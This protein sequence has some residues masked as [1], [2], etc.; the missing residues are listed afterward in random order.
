[1][2]EDLHGRVMMKH[3]R[4]SLVDDGGDLITL[5]PRGHC[6]TTWTV[7]FLIQEIL[8]NKEIAIGIMSGTEKLAKEIASLMA[9]SM[10][11][12]K[13]LQECFPDVVPTDANPPKQW[14]IRGYRLPTR[15]SNRVDPTLVVGSVSSNVTGTHPDILLLD[16]I[17]FGRKQAELAAAEEAYLKVTAIMPPQGRI[18]ING[19]R[20][21]D[22]DLYGKILSGDYS[23]NLGPYKPLVLSCW[24]NAQKTEPIYP[25]EVRSGMTKVSGF[26]Y[27]DL[28]RRK[29]N[30]LFF[31]NCQYLNDPAPEEDQQ[32]KVSDLQYFKPED[33][34]VFDRAH[35]IGVEI[36]GPSVTFPTI[37]YQVTRELNLSIFLQEIS[38]PRRKKAEGAVYAT[39]GKEDRI[40]GAVAPLMMNQNLYLAEW[41]ATDRGGLVDEIRRFGASR[42]DDV[43][44]AL[45]MA[46][47]Y[48]AS[49]IRPEP[50]QNARLHIAADLA[51]SENN[52]ADWS[53]FIAYAVDFKGRGFVIDYKRFRQKSPVIIAQELIK[54]YQSINAQASRV[55]YNNNRTTKFARSYA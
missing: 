31:F 36:V 9:E 7:P 8:N 4:Q 32:M 43:I 55:P 44:D 22:G 27:D 49:G 28:Q 19:T 42:H 23:G 53:V 18:L 21:D 54:F 48:M 46:I 2:D 15:E 39:T 6:K 12:N 51:F 14:G 30:N 38:P 24:N 34:P 50:G 35:A 41:M 20:W 16:D 1:M 45:H 5:I 47:A 17:V 52:D 37:F 25:K 3:Y 13:V 33:A 10:S 26:S 11:G 29:A 40:L